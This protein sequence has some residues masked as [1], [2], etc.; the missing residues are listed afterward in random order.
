VY[1]RPAERHSA[2]DVDLVGWS[3]VGR[4]AGWCTCCSCGGIRHGSILTS[5]RGT[6]T[7]RPAF[8][9]KFLPRVPLVAADDDDGAQGRDGRGAAER[10][11]D[12]NDA[13][14][15]KLAGT[16]DSN[17]PSRAARNRHSGYNRLPQM[18]VK[19]GRGVVNRLRMQT[20]DRERGTRREKGGKTCGKRFPANYHARYSSRFN[21]SDNKVGRAQIKG[22]RGGGRMHRTFSV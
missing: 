17:Q 6:D 7:P 19:H 20:R 3:A 13:A 10:E 5:V 12:S 14:Y 9:Q 1:A 16:A 4:S 21:Y 2:L 18:A 8:L 22:K 15:R 11:R